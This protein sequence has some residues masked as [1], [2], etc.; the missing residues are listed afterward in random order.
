[1]LESWEIL[2]ARVAV[3]KACDAACSPS[4]RESGSRPLIGR[5]DLW[6][7]GAFFV[8]EAPNRADTFD[9]DKGYPTYDR[10]TDP[11]GRFTRRLLHEELQLDVRFFQVTNAVLCLPRSQEGKYPVET[12]Q[13]R[14]CSQLLTDQIAAIHPLVVVPVGAR[15]LNA[16]RMI[17]D[18]RIRR[19]KDAVARR[20]PWAGRW[21]FP[22]YHPSLLGRH[23]TTGRSE[24]DQRSDWRAL[25]QCLLDLGAQIP[26]PSKST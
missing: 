5:F 26:V 12:A 6:R 22:V 14:Q 9:P 7:N 17:D 21:L 11:T 1:M 20:I 8:F 25:R 15:A 24:S 16:T 18:H 19:M 4:L 10:D 2:K 3:C 13:L 23:P